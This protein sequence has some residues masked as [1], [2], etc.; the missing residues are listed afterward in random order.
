L[1]SRLVIPA[2][3]L[4]AAAYMKGRWDACPAAAERAP[5]PEPAAGLR[6]S[7]V[8]AETAATLAPMPAP[9]PAGGP[10]RA[11]GEAGLDLAGLA[12]WSGQPAAPALRRRRALA[13]GDRDLDR[14]A[15]WIGAPVARLVR[16][17]A[18]RQPDPLPLAE[19]SAPLAPPAAKEFSVAPRV[20]E[21]G[22][23]SLGG[24]AVAPGHLAVCGVTFRERL[25]DR[26]DAGA[27]R[28]VVEAGDNVAD[29]GLVVLGDPGF[30]P[31]EE[32]FTLMLAAAA[33]GVFAAAGR[34]E[35]LAV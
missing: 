3:L 21:S 7:P 32:G 14:L 16:A 13:P 25:A 31:D 2:A 34:Y 27:V 18:P 8:P 23:F 6:P 17:A 30:A 4:V 29:G 28:L 20:R 35:V 15:E 5:E 26:V 9:A 11:R 1:R 22:R 24:W 19:W 10:G 33:P 12:E